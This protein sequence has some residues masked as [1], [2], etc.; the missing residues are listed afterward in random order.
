MYR[1]TAFK[2]IHAV[3]I[4]KMKQRP[5]KNPRRIQQGHF[6]K[7]AFFF[8]S[9]LHLAL[10]MGALSDFPILDRRYAQRLLEEFEHAKP[11]LQTLAEVD[12]EEEVAV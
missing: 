3:K 1:V 6:L 2:V 9:D 8:I 11:Y 4:F 7:D 12:E 10:A 5:D